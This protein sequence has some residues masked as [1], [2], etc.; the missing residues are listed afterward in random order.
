MK[1]AFSFKRMPAAAAALATVGLLTAGTAVAAPSSDS[2]TG[3][4]AVQAAGKWRGFSE[5]GFSGPDNEFSGSTGS[6]T[7]VGSNWNDRV[8]SART[9]DTAV[10]VELWEHANCTGWSITIDDSGYGNIGPWVSA[11]RVTT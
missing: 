2:T 4:A 6:C 7:Y 8:R 5:T 9:G 1:M 11:F 3:T 10:R